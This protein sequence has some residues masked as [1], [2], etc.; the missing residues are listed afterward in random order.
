M[1]AVATRVRALRR[2]RARDLGL[3]QRLPLK[4][5]TFLETNADPLCLDAL[6]TPRSDVAVVGGSLP[7]LPVSSTMSLADARRDA[8]RIFT[9][10]DGFST[11][12]WRRTPVSKRG[13]VEVA[14]SLRCLKK[15][16]P[17]GDSR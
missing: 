4:L 7:Q 15:S 11:S 3:A 14:N 17:R 10:A 13:D 2:P 9:G 12:T 6:A 5:A 1:Q 16:A 8:S